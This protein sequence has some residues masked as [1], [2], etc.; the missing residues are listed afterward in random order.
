MLRAHRKARGFHESLRVGRTLL[1][2]GDGTRLDELGLLVAA[3]G[4]PI[5]PGT[6]LGFYTGTWSPAES[7]YR[8]CGRHVLEVDDWRITPRL[9]EW[10]VCRGYDIVARVNEPPRDRRANCSFVRFVND[11]E[12]RTVGNRKRVI[13]ASV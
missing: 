6:F 8:G 5:A 2:D 13:T 11:A 9:G 7:A 1:T 12:L 4:C 3:N 10:W